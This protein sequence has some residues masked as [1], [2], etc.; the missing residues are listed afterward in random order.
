MKTLLLL[1][2]FIPAAIFSQTIKQDSIW[3]PMK[4][5]I[6]DW[7]GKGGGEPG[8]GE[9]ER[10]YKW[11]FN[12]KY[13][14]IHNKSSY[15]PSPANATGEVHEDAGFFSY[16][17]SRKVFVLRQFHKEGFVNQY[18][19]DS[20]SP[21]GKTIVF[22]T[23]SIENIPLGW[24]AK[25]TYKLLNPDEFQETFELASPNENFTP[26]STALFKRKSNL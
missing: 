7:T 1:I 4:F 20:I 5:F 15:P 11:I 16:D 3:M 21:D 2:S 8:F 6:G 12:G 22:I 17:K 9:Y 13:I 14:E 19:L 18:K 24:R 25:E 10:S 23:E 26:Y